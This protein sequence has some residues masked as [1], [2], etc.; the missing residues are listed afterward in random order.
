MI[1][2]RPRPRRSW[3]KTP[4]VIPGLVF[5]FMVLS[6]TALPGVLIGWFILN[7]AIEECM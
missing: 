1:Y 4:V 6:T 3:W 2:P 5:F 7:A